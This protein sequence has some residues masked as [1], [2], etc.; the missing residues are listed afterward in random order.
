MK[1]ITIKQWLNNHF[2]ELDSYDTHCKPLFYNC[3]DPREKTFQGSGHVLGGGPEFEARQRQKEHDQAKGSLQR[4]HKAVK[5]KNK[6][7]VS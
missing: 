1:I 7:I 6:N 2:N 4:Q 5:N 3:S